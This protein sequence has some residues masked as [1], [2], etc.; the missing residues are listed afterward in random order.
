MSTC[1][2]IADLRDPNTSDS[3]FDEFVS[4]IILGDNNH[5]NHSSLGSSWS[6]RSISIFSFNFHRGFVFFVWWGK[7]LSN[8][9]LFILNG[10]PRRQD[11]IKVKPDNLILKYGD[12]FTI[13]LTNFA[14]TSIFGVNILFCFVRS[15]K[16]ASKHTSFNC[17]LIDNNTIL[18][19]IASKARHRHNW[20][21]SDRHL[22]NRNVF[23]WLCCHKRTLRVV[24]KMRSGLHSNLC[25]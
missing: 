20:V 3:H 17:R 5:I 16:S 24:E 4:R 7:N 12:F 22:I 10:L 6:K 9:Y 15:I 8:K 19:V 13:R 2:F 21:T 1:K 11:T 18:L 25:V 14:Q 23:D